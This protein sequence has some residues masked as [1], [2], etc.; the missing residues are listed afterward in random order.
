MAAAGSIVM[1]KLRRIALALV[2]FSLALVA[3]S[4]NASADELA[5][6]DEVLN[7][8]K[9]LDLK[10]TIITKSPG[11]SKTTLKLRMRMR[12]KAGNN[13]QLTEISAPSDMKGTKVLIRSTTQ[14]YIYLPAFKKI[15]RIASHLTEQGF[16][17]T[18]LSQRELSLTEYSKFYT[19]KVKSDKGGEMVLQL[20][21]KNDE[22]PYKTIQLT[23]EKK[24]HHLKEIHYFNDSGK[25][26]KIEKRSGYICEGKICMAKKQVVHD[27][28]SKV[29]STLTLKKHKFDSK[30]KPSLFSK[31][32]LQK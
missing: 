22:A 26:V 8:W 29:K 24:S 13:Q 4:S 17:G 6:L 1:K 9:S 27:L 20:N 14:M 21:A 7:R 32:Y 19:S 15:R 30:M 16:L 28:T 12:K 10:Y 25:K 18:A 5:K 23:V 3:F 2:A 31:R 11:S